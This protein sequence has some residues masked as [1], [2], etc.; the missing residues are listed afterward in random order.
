MTAAKAES[1]R[2]GMATRLS[3]ALLMNG[4]QLQHHPVGTCFIFNL[5]AS[6]YISSWN[7]TGGYRN[8]SLLLLTLHP[9]LWQGTWHPHAT[10]SQKP[11]S[12]IHQLTSLSCESTTLLHVFSLPFHQG[13]K[14]NWNLNGNVADTQPETK[15]NQTRSSRWCHALC[16]TN[17][18]FPFIIHLTICT[19]LQFE[20]RSPCCF[21]IG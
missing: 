13:K 3:A 20:F 17:D 9:W 18:I 6:L 4:R 8:Y 1:Y 16:Y 21:F 2:S 10:G 15:Q 19:N 14:K 11:C 5:P 12:Q 7:E